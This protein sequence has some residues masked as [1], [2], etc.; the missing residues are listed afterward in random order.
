MKMNYNVIPIFQGKTITIP[1]VHPVVLIGTREDKNFTF[2]F[3]NDG[4]HYY[5]FV[6]L[7]QGVINNNLP[8]FLECSF[9]DL[10]IESVNQY[11]DRSRHGLPDNIFASTL[12]K[13][14]NCAQPRN[15]A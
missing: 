11:C 15:I 6:T 10:L 1:F 4:D 13:K 5:I 9:K 14:Q 7:Q 12:K 8:N 3:S 2:I